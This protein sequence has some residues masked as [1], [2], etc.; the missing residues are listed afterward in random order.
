MLWYHVITPREEK[1]IS[2]SNK[3]WYLGLME[4]AQ[5]LDSI[6]MDAYKEKVR[7]TI[8]NALQ[9]SRVSTKNY[10]INSNRIKLLVETIEQKRDSCN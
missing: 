3:Q 7:S 2:Q 5:Q 1:Y 4:H 8:Q 9:L 10:L 6:T